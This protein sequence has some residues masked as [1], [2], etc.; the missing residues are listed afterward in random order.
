MSRER[1]C[2]YNYSL[3]A[4]GLRFNNDDCGMRVELL[5]QNKALQQ[6]ISTL[7]A[8]LHALRWVAVTEGLPEGR[9]VWLVLKRERYGDSLNRVEIYRSLDE[10]ASRWRGFAGTYSHWMPIILPQEKK[11]EIKN[12]QD[13]KS[14]TCESKEE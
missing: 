10:N 7:Q 13:R 6:Q 11:D 4:K 2:P 8:Q 1:T 12:P 14:E 5:R 3:A 9:G